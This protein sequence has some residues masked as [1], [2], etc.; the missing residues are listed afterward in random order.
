MAANVPR[1]QDTDGTKWKTANLV[2][3]AKTDL[4][5]VLSC[6]IVIL[7]DSISKTLISFLIRDRQQ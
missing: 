4:L 6:M 3:I 5:T 7:H 2:E 1:Q